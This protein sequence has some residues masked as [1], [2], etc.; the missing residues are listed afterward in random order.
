MCVRIC[1]ARMICIF[2]QGRSD[3]LYGVFISFAENPTTHVGCII[4]W[5][6]KVKEVVW[7]KRL[8]F[9]IAHAFNIELRP[10]M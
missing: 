10:N 5:L 2:T 3:S 1:E 6:R 4:V 7:N 9:N 8:E